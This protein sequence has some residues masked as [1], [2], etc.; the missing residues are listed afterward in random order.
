MAPQ[1]PITS[2][3]C[4]ARRCRRFSNGEESAADPHVPSMKSMVNDQ[5]KAVISRKDRV[6]QLQPGPDWTVINDDLTDSGR[7]GRSER[8]SAKSPVPCDGKIRPG[9]DDHRDV[10]GESGRPGRRDRREGPS[11]R[12]WKWSRT[13]TTSGSSLDWTPKASYSGIPSPPPFRDTSGMRSAKSGLIADESLQETLR[14]TDRTVVVHHH[15]PPD[16]V[17]L[18]TGGCPLGQKNRLANTRGRRHKGEGIGESPSRLSDWTTP[19]WHR[20]RVGAS[21]WSRFTAR[22][23]IILLG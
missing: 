15:L 19:V 8:R 7:A 17:Q 13:T 11:E 3:G 6:Q 23:A 9:R 18:R 10:G 16:K 2:P 21:A 1:R 12:W 5:R 22:N 4:L 14:K 20:E